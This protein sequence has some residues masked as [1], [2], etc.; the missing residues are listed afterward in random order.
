[1]SQLLDQHVYI[2]V[3]THGPLPAGVYVH[4]VSDYKIYNINCLI[5]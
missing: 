2:S 1:M 4:Q 3:K 5:M